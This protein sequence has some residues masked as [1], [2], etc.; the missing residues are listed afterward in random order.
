MIRMVAMSTLAA[1]ATVAGAGCGGGH[2]YDAQEFV[3]AINEEGAGL[4][5][6]DELLGQSGAET[7]AIHFEGPDGAPSGSGSGAASPSHAHG[8]ASLTVTDSGEAGVKEYERCEGAVTLICFRAANVV[9]ILQ[10]SVSQEDV[11]SLEA[12]FQGLSTD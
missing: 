3:A 1:L 7:Y 9:L 11:A 4:V 10:G 12:S 5:L 8:G 2:T 6:G